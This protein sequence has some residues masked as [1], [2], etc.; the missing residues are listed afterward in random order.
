[1]NHASIYENLPV[2]ANARQVDT[3]YFTAFNHFT[4]N[5]KSRY[6]CICFIGELFQGE[7]SPFRTSVQIQLPYP[8][9]TLASLPGLNG[10]PS[11]LPFTGKDLQPF[12]GETLPDIQDLFCQID[13]RGES[14]CYRKQ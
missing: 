5:R 14:D 8:D 2:A 6:E 13:R 10:K 12:R 3:V 4:V 11:R 9:G 7:K 1:M